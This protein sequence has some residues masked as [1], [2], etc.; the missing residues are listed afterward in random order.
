M[1]GVTQVQFDLQGAL[2]PSCYQGNTPISFNPSAESAAGAPGSGSTCPG[3]P[4]QQSGARFVSQ[5]ALIDSRS[6]ALSP[7]GCIETNAATL[8]YFDKLV[9]DPCGSF[10]DHRMTSPAFP[11]ICVVFR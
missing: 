8:G 9:A 4:R 3:S 7:A 6:C 11:L 5:Q 2:C 10:F 1:K